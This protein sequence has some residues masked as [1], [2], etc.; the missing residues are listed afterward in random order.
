MEYETAGDPMTGMKWTRKATEK[1]AAELLRSFGIGV[2]AKTVARLLKK[3]KFS[4]RVN[5]KKVSNSN[6]SRVDRNQQ[7][8][9]IADLRESCAKNGNPMISVDSKKKEKIGRF[10]NAGRAWGQT[11]R[12][13]NDHDF[14][15]L[16]IG[17]AT[18]NGLYDM[19]ANR[20]SMFVGTSY[21]TPA[22]AVENIERWWRY[23]GKKGYPHK[24]HLTILADAGGSNGCRTR[25][26]K[27]HLQ[28]KLCNRH[29]LSVTVAHYPPG[30]SKWNPIERQV[31]ARISKNWEGVPL[32]TYETALNYIRTTTTKTGL[33]VKAYLIEKKYG[34]GEKISDQLMSELS[35]VTNGI[36]PQWNYT[37][38]PN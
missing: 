17:K 27:Y 37:I 19:L 34:K 30:C 14:P 18:P 26:W 13:V 25:A 2:G 22:F 16:A 21:D 9:N 10:K 6:V 7:F 3:I 11:A 33:R 24:T 35:I 5:H 8:S 28:H 15:S 1:V 12:K 36:L 4:L 38:H 31:F 29:G 32:E 23:D 20:A